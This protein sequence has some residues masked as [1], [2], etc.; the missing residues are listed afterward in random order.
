MLSIKQI[1][2]KQSFLKGLF[3]Y[4]LSFLF[5]AFMGAL[6]KPISG[7]VPTTVILFSQNFIGL[8]FVVAIFPFYS[9]LSLRTKRIKMHLFRAFVGVLGMFFLFFSIKVIDLT[10][11]VLLVYSAP[12]FMPIIALILFKQKV[13]LKTWLSILVGFLGIILV[14]QPNTKIFHMGSLVGVMWKNCQKLG[15]GV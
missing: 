5:F 7:N 4:I 14:L 15:F 11:A 12:I 13:S 9:S 1:E 2:Q 6:S 3:F 8:V 10:N